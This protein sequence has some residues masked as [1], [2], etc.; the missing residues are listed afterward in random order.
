MRDRCT[1]ARAPIANWK[2]KKYLR[3]KEFITRES[4]D[5][6]AVQQKKDTPLLYVEVPLL[7]EEDIS[8]IRDKLSELLESDIDPVLKISELKDPIPES[9]SEAS[10]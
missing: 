1:F 9:P 10:S 4:V 8:V 2:T 5:Y 3:L 7:K 6:M